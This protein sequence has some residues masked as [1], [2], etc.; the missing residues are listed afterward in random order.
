MGRKVLTCRRGISN[1]ENALQNL[2]QISSYDK[3]K[4][5][6]SLQTSGRS[7]PKI[8]SPETDFSALLL[9]MELESKKVP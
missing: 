5:Y 3:C 1:T 9:E 4:I 8:C 6:T 2:R 7:V